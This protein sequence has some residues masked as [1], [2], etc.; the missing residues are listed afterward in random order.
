MSKFTNLTIGVLALQGDFER[1]QYQINLVGATP[2][3]V[4][5]AEDLKDLDGLIIPG[6]ESTTMNYLIDRFEIRQ[7]LLESAKS[8]P[9]WGTCAGMILMAREIA[10]NQ[11]GVETLNLMDMTVQRMGY[12]RQ[13]Y[14]VDETVPAT[15]NGSPVILTATF[16]RAP[17]ITRTGDGLEVLANYDDV[18][19][20]VQSQDHMACSFHTELDN[21]TKLLEYFLTH[22]VLKKRS[23]NV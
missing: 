20:L 10:D 23:Q 16:I 13:I 17:R 18:P 7:A 4:R 6:G 21:D 8:I 5:L 1:H 15:L 14:S 11:A 9:Y 2:R 12:G 3:E 22:F 19:V